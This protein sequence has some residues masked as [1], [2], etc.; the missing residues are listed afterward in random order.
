MLSSVMA[1]GENKQWLDV[2]YVGDGIEG[3]KMDIHVPDDGQETHKV[4]VII[5]GSAWFANNAKAMAY[6]SIGKPLNEAGFAVV[7]IN[8]R[9]SV[10]AKYPAQINDVKA[11]IR[12]VRGAAQTYG[13]DTSFVGIT[14][15]SSGGHLS[16]LAGTTNGVKTYKQGDVEVDI[17]G[18][19][20]AYT[21]ESSEVDAVVDW[22][23]PIDMARMENCET[24]K[25]EKS[26]EAVLIGGAPAENPDM[27]K[28]LSPIN[29]VSYG[30]PQFLVIHGNADPVVPYCQSELF[31]A[32]LKAHDCLADFI[33]VEGG[34][35]G[36]VTFN[37][38]TFRRMVDFFVA[39]AK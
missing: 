34:G 11:A 38:D 15:F 20:G 9:A 26:P 10:E 25:D 23:G 19:L 3:H 39:E 31:T 22:F 36:P 13:F 12:Y 4:V 32:Q 27:V 5:Y 16:S 8:H 7:S 1:L 14:G 33:T 29:Y 24:Y 35:H 21:S 18:S 2:D 37:D 17:E 30:D 28:L 6:E